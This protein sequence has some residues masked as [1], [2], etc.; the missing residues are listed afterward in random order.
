M[1][2]KFGGFHITYRGFQKKLLGQLSLNLSVFGFGFIYLFWIHTWEVDPH[3]DG[4]MFTAA[5]GFKDGLIPHRDFFAQYGP[6]TPILQGT[7]LKITEPT[8]INLKLLTSLSL[9][10]IAL[11]LFHQTK[12]RLGLVFAIV[13]TTG[14]VLT[15]PFGLIWSS[16][17]LTLFVLIAMTL[18]DWSIENNHLP[19][20]ALS[21]FISGILLGLAVFIRIHAIF[22]IFP[23][24][25]FVILLKVKNLYLFNIRFFVNG[26]FTGILTIIGYLFITDALSSYV[27]QCILWAF[28][29][30]SGG[31]NW[32]KSL[33]FDYLWIPFLGFLHV[34][35]Y[36]ILGR[37][38]KAKNRSTIV[39]FI[40]LIQSLIYVAF[41]WISELPRTGQQTLLNPKILLITLASKSHFAFM[42]T[43]VTL[44]VLAIA[45]LFLK[46]FN[47]KWFNQNYLKSLFFYIFGFGS[48]FQLYP[49]ADNYHI[50]FV[51]PIL[52]FSMLHNPQI[53]FLR[54]PNLLIPGI[55][56]MMI[57]ALLISFV[58]LASIPRIEFK[59]QVLKGMYGS[60]RTAESV[61][62]TMQALSNYAIVR[63]VRFDCPDGLYA[64]ASG[65]Y[66]ANNEKF[67][68]WGPNSL[69]NSRY[70][71]IFACYVDQIGIDQYK[72]L[73]WIP[74]SKTE[75]LPMSDSSG[76][77]YWN[78]LFERE[79]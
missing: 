26:I 32:S 16:I 46:K 65:H 66:L 31:P 2:S 40:L 39:V 71:Q 76:K 23:I 58:R 36:L 10:L 19:V 62:H 5:V 30:Y 45:F 78:V 22:I 69:K 70:V 18:L 28:L 41:L 75:Y 12:K 47:D 34:V 25:I 77:Q 54:K 27:S 15:G 56:I 42:Y 11:L 49:F 8:L 44:F 17:F 52:I 48:L 50:A 79:K 38:F 43:V 7:W 20:S 51:V 53:N 68:T 63:N 67:V 13:V 9:G 29:N 6:L 4:I 21:T 61:D 33:V 64:A 74:I 59:S 72:N 73:G 1:S 24:L 60:W 37:I 35:E 57:P 14:W 55:V 3:H